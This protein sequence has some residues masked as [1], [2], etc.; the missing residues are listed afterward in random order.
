V[1]TVAAVAAHKEIELDTLDVQIHRQTAEGAL[2]QTTFGI[3]LDLGS[4]LSRREKAI[5]FNSARR[6]EVHKLLAGGVD[7]HYRLGG[8]P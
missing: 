6:C 4:R 2:W 1:L 8:Q 5:L 7:F 3:E